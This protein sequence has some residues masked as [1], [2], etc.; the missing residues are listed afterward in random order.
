M[1]LRPDEDGEEEEEEEEEEDDK[2][3]EEARRLIVIVA[4]LLLSAGG[5]SG[6]SPAVQ[7]ISS[8][9]TLTFSITSY[10]SSDQYCL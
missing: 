1:Q 2:E 3:E 6:T 7:R 9:R 5:L 8:I 4:G 10:N